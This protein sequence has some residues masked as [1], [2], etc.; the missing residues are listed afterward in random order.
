MKRY[1]GVERNEKR[2]KSDRS[3][4]CEFWSAIQNPFSSFLFDPSKSLKE[5][6]LNEFCSHYYSLNR[7]EVGRLH[8]S[9]RIES[10]LFAMKTK[11]NSN[12]ALGLR[13]HSHRT[14]T[15]ECLT[16]QK[17]EINEWIHHSTNAVR[18]WEGKLSRSREC[19]TRQIPKTVRCKEQLKSRTELY[20]IGM[21]E[22]ESFS[23]SRP[24]AIRPVRAYVRARNATPSETVPRLRKVAVYYIEYFRVA[25]TLRLC[26]R[27]RSAHRLDNKFSIGFKFTHKLEWIFASANTKRH[28]S[29]WFGLRFE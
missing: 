26:H 9:H 20:G 28:T 8:Y 17:H 2:W 16:K 14:C 3:K 1:D 15:R 24:L 23:G 13:F 7:A 25:H 18:N 19:E 10:I 6:Y 22:I 21:I 11:R 4:N 29:I 27:H 5:E 12:D